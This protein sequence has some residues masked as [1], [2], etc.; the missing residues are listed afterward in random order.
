MS[1]QSNKKS[2][3]LY[4]HIPFCQSKCPYCDFY[5]TAGKADY[6]RYIDAVLLHLED[7]SE[8]LKNRVVDT[9]YIGGGTPSVL[10]K[11]LIC[12]LV[13]SIYDYLDVAPDAEVTLEANPATLNPSALKK[14]WKLGV[15]RLSMGL[16]SAVDEE[17]KTLGRIHTYA[18]FE[19]NFHAARDAGFD[20]ISVDLMYGIPG[21]TAESLRYSLETLVNLGPEHISL[22]G[23]KIEP[24]TPFG[25]MEDLV[26]PDE[27][28]QVDMYLDS[29]EYLESQGYYQYEISNFARDGRMSRHNLRYWN[30]EEYLGLGPGA[31]SYLNGTRFSFV[32]DT[33]LYI[34]AMEDL[35]KPLNII[36]EKY[37]I[38]P[39]ERIGEYVM[40]RLRLVEG[41][42]TREFSNLFG[43]DF[44]S[45]YGQYLPAYI[46]GGFMVKTPTGYALTPVG[47]CVSNEILS[48]ML[49]FDSDIVSGIADGTDR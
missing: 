30:C 44:D 18:Q 17:L 48:T 41:I 20:N 6:K 45:L 49:S 9:I 22:Y 19:Q 39:D 5:S 23:L 10:P 1:T 3:G 37:E 33:M 2:I 21:Q 42:D 40:L 34:D 12:D 11:G 29:I 35:S 43:V 14:L 26:L 36:D 16:Q 24:N 25:Q 47:M 32:R 28:E 31:H 15:G 4:I 7:Y 8:C 46:D 27:D 38:S 13:D